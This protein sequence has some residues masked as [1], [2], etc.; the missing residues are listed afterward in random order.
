MTGACSESGTAGE[1]VP[2]APRGS[3]GSLG[4]SFCTSTHASLDAQ[5]LTPQREVSRYTG[6]LS[7]PDSRSLAPEKGHHP[8][9]AGG[10]FLGLAAH[11]LNGQDTCAPPRPRSCGHALSLTARAS[12]TPKV[13]Q[14][15]D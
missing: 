13:N 9:W 11:G 2:S 4:I 10:A 1:G 3:E 7:N 8:S 15:I 6:N 12:T 5:S 14:Q